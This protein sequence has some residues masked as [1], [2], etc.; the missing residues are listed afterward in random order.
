MVIDDVAGVGLGVQG[1]RSGEGP[2]KPL[3]LADNGDAFGSTFLV[4]GIV[5]RPPTMSEFG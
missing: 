3:V 5:M 1:C 4:G 2:A